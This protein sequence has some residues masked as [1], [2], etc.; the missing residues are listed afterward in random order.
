M[1]P[2]TQ[3]V[4]AIGKY[5][6]SNKEINIFNDAK[7][8]AIILRAALGLKQ[9]HH[10]IHFALSFGVNNV[11]LHYFMVFLFQMIQSPLYI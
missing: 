11:K 5:Q 9:L 7:N 10:S 4:S 6:N 8:M 1:G 2:H 3:N